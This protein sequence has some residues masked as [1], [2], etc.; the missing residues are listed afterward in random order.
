MKPGALQ[1]GD[2][3]PAS[4]GTGTPG[5]DRR[6]TMDH[7]EDVTWSM[8]ETWRADRVYAPGYG[9]AVQYGRSR[10]AGRSVLWVP[11]ITRLRTSP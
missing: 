11:V 10:W 4:V 3:V 6:L 2:S 1:V 8:R 7:Q 9:I 5:P